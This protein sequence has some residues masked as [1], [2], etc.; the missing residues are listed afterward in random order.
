MKK[1]FV[2]SVAC[3]VIA[4]LFLMSIAP[5]V[6]AAFLPSEMIP[7]PQVKGHRSL[8]LQNIQKTLETKM[9]RERLNQ[10]G[11]S[12][13]EIQAKLSKLD[14]QQIHQ[15]ALSIDDMKVGGNGFEVLVVILLIAILI[16]VWFHV[17][18]TRVVVE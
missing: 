18:G 2:R 13:D 3:Y 4:G 7:S 10:L 5:K 6:D 17:T 12:Q 9:I 11:F 8:D 1:A 14:D 16:G 15:L